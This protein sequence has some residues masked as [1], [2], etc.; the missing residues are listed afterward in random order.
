MSILASW[1]SEETSP[2]ATL[3]VGAVLYAK[4]T[5]LYQKQLAL[6]S[7]DQY[8]IEHGSPRSI[9]NHV[10]TFLWYRPFLPDEGAVLDWGCNHAPDSCL[11]RMTYG[12]RLQLH[13]C[14][15]VDNGRYSV[16]HE[17]ADLSYTKLD[18]N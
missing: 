10:L 8:L 6:I 16:F 2:P 9:A 12:Q 14:D 1:R 11:L 13:G 15:F 7:P 18:Q 3:E 5:E 17:F 4:L